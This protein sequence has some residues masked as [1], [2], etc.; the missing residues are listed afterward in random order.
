M[1]LCNG[2]RLA[3]FHIN[4]LLLSIKMNHILEADGIF[5]E[6][7]S[8]RILSDIYIKAE[9][10][11]LTGLLGRNGEGKTCLLN[12]IYGNLIPQSR[13][14]R[15]DGVF[16]P[17][18]YKRSDLLSYLPQFS[19]IP[20]SLSLKRIFNDFAIDYEGLIQHFE[21]FKQHRNTSFGHLSGGQKR[22]IEVYCIIKT[23]S[24]FSILDEPFSHIMPIHVE[25]IKEILNQ[26]KRHKGFLITDHLFRH[27]VEISDSLYVLKDGKSYLTKN[28]ED[29]ETLGYARL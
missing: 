11:T 4:I 12:I 5:L 3:Y 20:K 14:V 17:H 21:E 1:D 22:L 19:F 23:R 16:L 7:D 27:I 18:A 8:R 13:S 10:G 2:F 9:T 29:I 6:F 24:F 25:V 15:I 26:E 28:I